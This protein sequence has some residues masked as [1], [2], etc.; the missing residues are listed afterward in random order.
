MK[1]I[2][3]DEELDIP[4]GIE[5]AVK[6]REVT[7]KGPRGELRKGFQHINLEIQHLKKAK[8]IKLI[9]WH[10][11][12]KHVA[13]LRTVKTHIKNM[14][15]GVTKGFEYRM[16]YVYAHF[17]IN[18]HIDGSEVE[19]RNFIGEKVI[20]RVKMLEGVKIEISTGLKDELILTAADIQQSTTV[21]NKDIR[22]FLDGVYVSERSTAFVTPVKGTQTSL[23]SFIKKELPSPATDSETQDYNKLSD[24]TKLSD[25]P[26]TPKSMKSRAVKKGAE[27]FMQEAE[28]KE[29]SS[30]E[31][32]GLELD[33]PVLGNRIL[34][35]NSKA[36]KRRLIFSSGEEDNEDE[37]DI[38]FIES[39]LKNKTISQRK[40]SRKANNKNDEEDEDE[41]ME[42]FIDDT[43][44]KS[45][46]DD[47]DNDYEN[48]DGEES[49][50]NYK[51]VIRKNQK[52][53]PKY[54]PLSKKF[55]SFV[56]TD[57]N[58]LDLT[59]SGTKKKKKEDKRYDW[60]EK[61]RDA[62]GNLEGSPNYDSRSLFIPKEAWD[63]FTPFEKQFWEIKC[64]HWD[65]IVFFKKGK[66]YE[67][68]ERDALIGH[69]EFDLKLTTRVNMC[70]VGVPE[71]S[72]EHWAAKFIAKSH[73][74]AKVD[75]METALGKEM[76][77]KATKTKE[78]KIIRRQLT[79]IFTAGTVVDG[80]LLTNDMSTYCILPSFGICFVDTSIAE[81]NFTSFQDD[82]DR[83]HF[84]TLIMQ[85]K[86]K[87][88]VYEKKML[89]KSSLRIINSCIHS[90]VMNALIPGKE[91]WDDSKTLD[92]LRLSRY[93][94]NKPQNTLSDNEEDDENNM[95]I[96][97]STVE[98][99]YDMKNW[100]KVIQEACGKPL[101][102]SA[103]GGLI[104]YLRLLKLDKELI[105]VKNFHNYDPIRHATSL[106]LDGQ[107]LANLE[108][109][110]NNMDGSDKG[111]VFNLLNHC[112]TS[113]GK[114]T[115][116]QWLCHPLLSVDRINERLDTVEELMKTHGFGDIFY[117]NFSK[118]PD[119]ERLISRIHAKS[120]RVK[121][122]VI[123]LE[124]F[125]K[126]AVCVISEKTMDEL[127]SLVNDFSSVKLIQLM[128][129]LP[130]LNSEL[131]Y[132]MDAFDYKTASEKGELIP[133]KG[134]DAEFDRINEVLKKIEN[135]LADHLS[136]M[137]KKLGCDKLVYKNVGKEIYQIEV[138]NNIQVPNDWQRL[139]RTQKV[140]RYWNADLQKL[141]RSFQET[142][143]YKSNI[144]KS[145]QGK[146]YEKFDINYQDWLLSVKIVAETDCLLSL[147]KSSLAL[148]EPRCRP[149]F[150]KEGPSVLEFEELRH[151][152]VMTG[153]ANDFIPNDTYL[154]GKEPNIIL[155]TGPNMG[156]GQSTF[157][158]ELSE[159]SRILHEA[160]PRSMVILD[161]LGRGTST[162]DGY[163]IA[164]SVLH[165][166]AT[167]IGCLGLFSTHYG[168]LTKEFSN[169]PN[170]ALKH[171]SC[172]MDQ[173]L[174]EVT[175]LY[176][177]VP[178]VCPK[179]YGMNVASMA[180]IPSQIVESAEV[181]ARKF[182]ESSK[183]NNTLTANGSNIQLSTQSDFV[184]LLRSI[185]KVKSDISDVG[186]RAMDNQTEHEKEKRETRI[187]KAIIR[188]IKK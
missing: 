104:W 61:V 27:V 75:Q 139:S 35:R 147:V 133:A 126:L 135:Q 48:D 140:C 84:E 34:R 59:E 6:A 12:R 7:V 49:P 55:K 41:Y 152:C 78:D 117:E 101:L 153:V 53:P 148:G 81:F 24:D 109:F 85:V 141:I 17:P 184:Y 69:S 166:L 155:L 182:E 164:Y 121:E 19:I 103:F 113:F 21:K 60:L 70:M 137:K 25:D 118:F 154:G 128:N 82:I 172:H 134:I 157:M 132:F 56:S 32:E 178:G 119:L 62:N 14:I 93:F 108:I 11:T 15:I 72:I 50:S 127:R 144:L 37:N 31:L 125:E 18:V 130:D 80:G 5:I 44:E 122:F 89:S 22:K 163:A 102:L 165:Y 20:R 114:R 97:Y 58:D 26:M 131:S 51:K 33:T 95:E 54:K 2:Y 158:V 29:G 36:F 124:S 40:K 9:V 47:N 57:N 106:I 151:P 176:K 107:T 39:P 116:K 183:L 65:T 23:W 100:P 74:V 1:D 73:K 76:R 38:N 68:Y 143:E 64:K 67:L 90:P 13:C 120:C 96:D 87:E 156:A 42:G 149:R 115:F 179:S 105:S 187:L 160:T 188:S 168:M 145:L 173:K 4:E 92:E 159:T 138:P 94:V 10:G 185:Q 181:I 142:L 86:P 98:N 46:D 28:E 112:V 129:K 177:L 170:I 146:F 66:F 43:L 186:D 136:A 161:E 99:C 71:A 167:Y 150:I 16:R 52:K 88:I 79:S 63:K 91:F 30:G 45:S 169:N 110:E 3:K 175:F 8:K 162:F 111:T 123:V 180:G 77:E 83:T 174:R 171:M